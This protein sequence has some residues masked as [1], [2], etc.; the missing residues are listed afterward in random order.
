MKLRRS[1]AVCDLLL[2]VG[3]GAVFAF[4]LL[5][6]RSI[7]FR[8]SLVIFALI[9]FHV[10]G[11]LKLSPRRLFAVIVSA[12]VAGAVVVGLQIYET[13][14]VFERADLL[15][16]KFTRQSDSPVFQAWTVFIAAGALRWLYER[17]LRS[18]PHAERVVEGVLVSASAMTAYYVSLPL[19][20]PLPV[21]GGSGS[22]S[23]AGVFLVLLSAA[24]LYRAFGDAPVAFFN[25][26]LARAQMVSSA[27]LLGVALVL[28]GMMHRC[29]PVDARSARGFIGAILGMSVFAVLVNAQ[30]SSERNRR[31]LR[32]AFIVFLGAALAAFWIFEV[33]MNRYIPRFDLFG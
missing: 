2:V 23:L 3:T 18:R 21:A 31:I 28:H 7:A 4:S 29:Y 15:A 33:R 25:E 26:P 10:P 6:W 24:Y 30:E 9:V 12:A 22:I 17:L 14:A 13:V 11:C 19:R 8:Y 16:D 5:T 27:L 20:V 1:A 32:L